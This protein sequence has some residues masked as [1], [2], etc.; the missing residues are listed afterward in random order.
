MHVDL[1]RSIATH[2]RSEYI[3][4]TRTEIGLKST[5]DV[6]NAI[7]LYHDRVEVS[8]LCLLTKSLF[9]QMQRDRGLLRIWEIGPDIRR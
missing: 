7:L 1:I 5:F 2:H 9:A 6:S 3:G 8:F 4:G